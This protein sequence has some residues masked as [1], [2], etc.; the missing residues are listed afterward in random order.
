MEKGW[1][2]RDGGEKGWRDRDGGEKGWRDRDG[3][4]KGWR[5]RDGVE[6]DG[7]TGM[8]RGAGIEGRGTAGG[9]SDGWGGQG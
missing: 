7:G 2:D 1:K 3:V 5:D 9:D 8:E 6:R 4:E